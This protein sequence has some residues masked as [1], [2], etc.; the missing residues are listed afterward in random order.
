ML[1]RRRQWRSNQNALVVT[2]AICSNA[3]QPRRKM[4]ALPAHGASAEPM[5]PETSMPSVQ[6]W[7]VLP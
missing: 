5:G 4:R 1:S 7:R 2:S 6:K 3:G